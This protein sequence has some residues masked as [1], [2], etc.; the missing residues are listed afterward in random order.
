MGWIR[1]YR[2]RPQGLR[3]DFGGPNSHR[4]YPAEPQRG[5]RHAPSDR[6]QRFRCTAIAGG[7]KDLGPISGVEMAITADPMENI[8]RKT[9][10][11]GV[12]GPVLA[13]SPR[14]HE[15][16]TR[17]SPFFA[18]WPASA[19][20]P[21]THPTRH[22]MKH[23]KPQPSRRT[24]LALTGTTRHTEAHL[25]HA[26]AFSL[27]WAGRWC[28]DAGSLRV[29]SS[30]LI[31]RAL[32]VYGQHLA[33]ADR[34]TEVREVRRCCSADTVSPEVH[35]AALHRLQAVPAD[36]PLPPLLALLHGPCEATAAARWA[37]LEAT[38][39]AFAADILAQPS[40]RARGA[41]QRKRA[42]AEGIELQTMANAAP[43]T[44][45][46]GIQ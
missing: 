22:T 36:E 46:Q 8:G 15:D 14:G 42:A 5:N 3:S 37:E 26:S 10:G 35:Q 45:P 19:L 18:T 2:L 30:G 9:A 31:R 27:E 44:T 28:T 1:R 13:R 38:A 4:P 21:A 23:N 24:V 33:A 29:P 25:D 41:L 17:D 20:R 32:A 39:E 7:I 40:S 43:P 11:S 6:W 12:P 34:A 16:H